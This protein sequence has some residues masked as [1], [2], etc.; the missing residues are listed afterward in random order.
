MCRPGIDLDGVRQGG[1][2]AT[3][4]LAPF[5][6]SHS[7]DGAWL[8]VDTLVPRGDTEIVISQVLSELQGQ[9]P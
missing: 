8:R 1:P 7:P 6:L 4:R 2:P 9:Q 3:H 5:V